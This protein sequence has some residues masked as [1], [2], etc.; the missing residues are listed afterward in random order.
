MLSFPPFPKDPGS[1]ASITKLRKNIFYYKMQIVEI[2]N[3]SSK[4]GS[5]RF[6]I[7]HSRKRAISKTII[8]NSNESFSLQQFSRQKIVSF[9]IIRL[10]VSIFVKF[11]CQK[12]KHHRRFHIGHPTNLVIFRSFS[13]SHL[14]NLWT[15]NCLLLK[16]GGKWKGGGDFCKQ[17]RTTTC[18]I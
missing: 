8:G 11:I 4:R 10:R 18:I 17:K 6:F 2:F 7:Y 12:A 1:A 3:H 13:L 14:C 15:R 9:L 5:P 16:I